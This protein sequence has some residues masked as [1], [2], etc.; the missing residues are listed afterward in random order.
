VSGPAQ[1]EE[2]FAPVEV[3]PDD[4]GEAPAARKSRSRRDE[5]EDDDRDRDRD[6]NAIQKPGSGIR[7]S[8]KDRDD[9]DDEDDRDRKRRRRRDEDDDDDDRGKK[10]KPKYQ[11]CPQCDAPDPVRVKWTAWGSFYGPAMFTHVR[12]QEC[13]YCYNGKTGGSNVIPATIFVTV[14]LVGILAIIGAFSWF[15]YNY[16]QAAKLP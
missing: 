11:P 3:E 15:I 8:R 4:S 2:D 14:P 10:K 6:K 7:S 9:E 13:G 5:D 1:D 16:I 12:C